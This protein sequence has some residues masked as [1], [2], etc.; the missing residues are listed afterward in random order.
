MH[1]INKADGYFL[2]QSRSLAIDRRGVSVDCVLY[3]VKLCA[4]RNPNS[5][6]IV[7]M[8]AWVLPSLL[9]PSRTSSS[10][11][12]C[13][14]FGKARQSSCR[15]RPY[16]ACLQRDQIA[17][18]LRGMLNRSPRKNRSDLLVVEARQTSREASQQF[19]LVLDLHSVMSPSALL[20][21]VHLPRKDRRSLDSADTTDS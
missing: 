18:L 1:G 13:A 12:V 6:S 14:L 8:H 9:F 20:H 7:C 4:V 16:R 21:D 15:S 19:R 5:L 11:D 2:L 3:I 10:L 17:S